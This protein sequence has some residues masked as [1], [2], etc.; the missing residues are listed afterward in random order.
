M[1]I[2]IIIHILLIN[3]YELQ[4]EYFVVWES[5]IVN[6]PFI[7]NVSNKK[8]V[9]FQSLRKLLLNGSKADLTVETSKLILHKACEQ[10]SDRVIFGVEL[11]I[12]SSSYFWTILYYF[13]FLD[14]YFAQINSIWRA[15]AKGVLPTFDATLY[16]SVSQDIQWANPRSLI[17]ETDRATRPFLAEKS[18]WHC[19][20]K[21]KTIY[22]V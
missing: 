3:I 14:V 4:L 15:R 2:P 20:S 18:L 16:Y 21:S 6:I 9:H 22:I 7:L 5:N 11:S 17:L 19:W 1:V 8:L 13:V 10:V 12:L